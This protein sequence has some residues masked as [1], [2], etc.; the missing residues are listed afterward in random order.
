MHNMARNFF[1]QRSSRVRTKNYARERRES[2]Y[3]LLVMVALYDA[4][5]S[6]ICENYIPSVRRLDIPY[7][8]NVVQDY[9]ST[10]SVS[11]QSRG[12]PQDVV[13]KRDHGLIMSHQVIGTRRARSGNSSILH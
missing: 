10:V 5:I 3:I 9:L 12:C 7:S 1:Y 11:V 2:L 6:L 8:D 13:D 4:I